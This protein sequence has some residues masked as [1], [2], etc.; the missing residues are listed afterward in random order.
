MLNNHNLIPYRET[1][2]FR[3]RMELGSV[4]QLVASAV[5]TSQIPACVSCVTARCDI[6]NATCICQN[7][8]YSSEMDACMFRSCRMS[9]AL[10]ALPPAL[11][12]RTIRNG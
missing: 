4:V 3:P 1:M 6:R 7:D 11:L 9:D 12:S 5:N 8:G 2:G 10:C